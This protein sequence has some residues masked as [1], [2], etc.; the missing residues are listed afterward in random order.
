[1]LQYHPPGEQGF[2]GYFQEQI[3]KLYADAQRAHFTVG[4]TNSGDEKK[5]AAELAEQRCSYELCGGSTTAGITEDARGDLVMVHPE[6]YKEA[7]DGLQSEVKRM[8]TLCHAK[9][10]QIGAIAAQLEATVKQ[11]LKY[12]H[13]HTVASLAQTYH[14]DVSKILTWGSVK[15]AIARMEVDLADLHNARQ[16]SYNQFEF[17][18]PEYTQEDLENIEKTEKDLREL[19]ERIH[20]I[21]KLPEEVA[22]L[23]DADSGY[24]IGS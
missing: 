24:H 2:K 13:E 10:K 7:A 15:D 23:T 14:E 18:W 11:N 1:M 21:E 8:R 19:A 5:A 12:Y 4:R 22:A 9:L 16:Y 17:G 3:E 20:G 6:E